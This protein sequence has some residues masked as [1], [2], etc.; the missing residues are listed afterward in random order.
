MK[1]FEELK[2]A[3]SLLAEHPPGVQGPAGVFLHAVEAW[4]GGRDAYP[5]R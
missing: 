4:Q 2:K 3:M 5:G 1:Y